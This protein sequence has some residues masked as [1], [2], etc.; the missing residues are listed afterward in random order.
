MAGVIIRD[1]DKR[2]VLSVDLA[3]I[4]ETVGERA[5]RSR[6]R[7][8]GVETTGGETAEDLYR[9]CDNGAVVTGDRL[10][11][12]ARGLWQIIEG[13][14][15]AYDND[16]DVP[17]LMVRAVDSCWWGVVTD[18]LVALAKLKRVFREIIDVPESEI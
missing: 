2:G 6:W 4:M 15:E 8:T 17:W 16:L 1:T 18:D 7:V 10:L 9:V 5:L 13:I 3:P 12:L 11:E 14:F